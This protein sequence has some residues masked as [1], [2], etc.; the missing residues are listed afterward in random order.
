MKCDNQ[1][2]LTFAKN[3]KHHSRTKYIDIQHD[4]IW[5][6]IEMEVIDMKYCAT[7]DMLAD[8][9]TKALVKDR[10]YKLTKGLGLLAFDQ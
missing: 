2:C 6:K 9:L 1:G 5:E 8:L 4:F 3:P 10:Y 7:E